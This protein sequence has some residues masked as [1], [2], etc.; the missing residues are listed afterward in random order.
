MGVN[1]EVVELIFFQFCVKSRSSP[2]VT[3]PRIDLEQATVHRLHKSNRLLLLLLLP[4]E[5]VPIELVVVQIFPGLERLFWFNDLEDV[6]FEDDF[7]AVADLF[8]EAG[9]VVVDF[10]L[11]ANDDDDDD[12]AT[13]PPLLLLLAYEAEW[14]PVKIRS[15]ANSTLNELERNVCDKSLSETFMPIPV[16]KSRRVDSLFRKEE[17]LESVIFYVICDVMWC[18]PTCVIQVNL[19]WIA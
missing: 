13:P 6:A 9:V 3:R 1:E 11:A 14:S 15:N 8:L 4:I 19:P 5:L 7:M 18:V 12:D 2:W 10:E 17:L 16:T